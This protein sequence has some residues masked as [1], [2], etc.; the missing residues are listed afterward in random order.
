M[1]NEKGGKLYDAAKRG[2]LDKV[3]QLLLEGATVH[4]RSWFGWTP[5]TMAAYKY[6]HAGY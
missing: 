1:D 5:C 3:K 4:H 2:D 6:V